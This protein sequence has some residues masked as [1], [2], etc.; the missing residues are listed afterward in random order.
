MPGPECQALW[1]DLVVA[2]ASI[3]TRASSAHCCRAG[4]ASLAVLAGITVNP[5][6]QLW[7]VDGR[8][9]EQPEGVG[10]L[11]HCQARLER[12]AVGE[13]L[14]GEAHARK[15]LLSALFGGLLLQPV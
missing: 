12:A 7:L 5:G 1:A 6:W 2:P 15:A 4:D 13:E 14:G 8:I 11:G 3:S 10:G 9:V